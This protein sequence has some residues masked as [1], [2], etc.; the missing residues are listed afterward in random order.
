LP[1][2]GAASPISP[3]P[4]V[5]QPQGLNLT[6]ASDASGAPLRKSEAAP[7]T[8]AASAEE[9]AAVGGA[10]VPIMGNVVNMRIDD[11]KTKTELVID[12]SADAPAAAKLV[13]NGKTLV[14]DLRHFTWSGAA[15]WEADHKKLI[16]GG[17]VREGRLYVDLKRAAELN[18]RFAAPSDGEQNYRLIIDLSNKTLSGKKV[19]KAEAP[20]SAAHKAAKASAAPAPAPTPTPAPAAAPQP[21]APPPATGA[22]FP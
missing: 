17:Y 16:S 8:P 7:V 14:V 11:Q 15:S 21:A 18:A 10:P 1:P 2:K 6:P 3:V 22:D 20:R 12:V 4:A 19:Q 5:S 13:N 9:A